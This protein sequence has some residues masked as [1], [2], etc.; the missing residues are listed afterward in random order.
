MRIKFDPIGGGLSR[1]NMER[2]MN[3]YGRLVAAIALSLL[4]IIP[5]RGDEVGDGDG[6]GNVDESVEQLASV[7]SEFI[8]LFMFVGILLGTFTTHLLS[9]IALPI[10]YTVLMYLEGLFLALFMQKVHIGRFGQA[11]EVWGDINPDLLLYSFLPILLFGEA[12]S[13]NW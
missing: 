9:R 1:E 2:L 11:V 12:M 7:R 4:V 13:L 8:I 10:P 3:K 5:V 6:E